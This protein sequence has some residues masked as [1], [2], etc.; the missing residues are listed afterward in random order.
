[1]FPQFTSPLPGNLAL[2]GVRLRATE[3]RDQPPT[4]WAFSSLVNAVARYALAYGKMNSAFGRNV[5]AY[6]TRYNF[7]LDD[8][9]RLN[10]EFMFN[11][12]M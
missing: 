11:Y 9:C 10:R 8:Y 7:V 5:A 1:M 3:M 2:A 12:S 4:Q 6:C